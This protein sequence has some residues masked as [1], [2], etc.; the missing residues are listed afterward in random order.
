M[1]GATIP[2]LRPRLLPALLLAA[3]LWWLVRVSPTAAVAQRIYAGLRRAGILGRKLFTKRAA[4]IRMA[5][6]A[7]GRF[8]GVS[9]LRRKA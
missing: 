6:K 1:T 4:W 5:R 9:A 7:R 8:P 2:R 3:A